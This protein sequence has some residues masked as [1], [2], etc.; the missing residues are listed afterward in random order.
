MTQAKLFYYG[1]SHAWAV[2]A[3]LAYL[4]TRVQTVPNPAAK[5]RVHGRLR[6]FPSFAQ[7]FAFQPGDNLYTD[8]PCRVW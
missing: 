3:Q 6:Y 8:T 1:F 5:F 7:M 4:R 2:S